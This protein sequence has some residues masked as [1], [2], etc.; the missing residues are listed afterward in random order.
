D[1]LFLT[2][3]ATDGNGNTPEFS[4]C[5]KVDGGSVSAGSATPAAGGAVV[6]SGDGLAPGS[7]ADVTLRSDP[8]LLGHVVASSS[9]RFSTT[10]TIP[11]GT[12][13]GPHT[14]EVT[15]TAPG[16][17]PRVLDLDVWVVEPTVTPPVLT[18][19]DPI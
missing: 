2:A 9:G 13:L 15:G 12:E 11:A 6:V 14:I 5:L 16:G 19:P 4:R 18:L 17:G 8:V 3:T 7:S 10:V 1:A